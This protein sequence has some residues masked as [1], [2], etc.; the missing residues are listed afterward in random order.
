M[1]QEV[2]KKLL[3]EKYEVLK[4][5]EDD[6]EEQKCALREREQALEDKRNKHFVIVRLS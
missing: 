1:K 5:D 2:K 6:N 4:S 3:E